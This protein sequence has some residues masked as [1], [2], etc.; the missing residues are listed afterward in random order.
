VEE[1]FLQRHAHTETI[2]LAEAEN[3]WNL[4]KALVDNLQAGGVENFFPVQAK[5]IPQLMSNN[6]HPCVHTRDLCVSAPT[7]KLLS[8]LRH[9]I[10]VLCGV[11]SGKTIAY[12]V[13]VICYLSSLARARGN[14]T[15][16]IPFN[17]NR[18]L[19]ALF[20]LPSRELAQQVYA[21]TVRLAQGVCIHVFIG[22]L[23]TGSCRV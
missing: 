11:G 1:S 8:I 18:R 2:S 16:Q 13:P 15:L 5:V 6:K 21:V 7:G 4:P 10:N 20:M 14:G 3:V 12:V 22:V 19:T 17:F 9:S 23:I